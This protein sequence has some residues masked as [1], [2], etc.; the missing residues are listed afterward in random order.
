[1]VYVRIDN[2]E[3]VSVEAREAFLDY[4]TIATSM[5]KDCELVEIQQND[6]GDVLL[7]LD[8]GDFDVNVHN[9]MLLAGLGVP[10]LFA[11]DE[12]W[13]TYYLTDEDGEDLYFAGSVAQPEDED[14][15][16]GCEDGVCEA[17]FNQ[18]REDFGLY[19]PAAPLFPFHL[20]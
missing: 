9:V 14:E 17:E 6:D 1:M 3:F 13:L 15:D 8:M 5:Y 16:C 4:L 2:G 11:F 7:S 20:N 10:S 12:G 18:I 19:V